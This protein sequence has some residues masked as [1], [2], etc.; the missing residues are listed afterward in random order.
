M[1]FGELCDFNLEQKNKEE[2][3]NLIYPFRATALHYFAMTSNY[4]GIITCIEIGVVYNQ[5]LFGKTPLDYAF[6]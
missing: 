5:D 4:K 6:E 1:S 3:K 2:L